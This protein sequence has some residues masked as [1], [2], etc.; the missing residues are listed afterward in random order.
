MSGRKCRDCPALFTPSDVRSLLCPGCKKA[1]RAENHRRQ[2]QR[3]WA[4]QPES[5]RSVLYRKQWQGQQRRFQKLP[6][7][8]QGVVNAIGNLRR[9][10]SEEQNRRS[11]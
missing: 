11:A 7:E 2:M 9:R 6:V 4:R 8:L 3:W 5:S 1:R 10:I